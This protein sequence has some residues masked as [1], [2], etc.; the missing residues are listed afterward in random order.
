MQSVMIDPLALLLNLSL[1]LFF[2]LMYIPLIY[3]TVYRVVFEK[4]TKA[5]E[6]MRIMGMTDFPYWSSWLAYYTIVNTAI[7]TGVWF[8]LM[9][10][11]IDR[12]SAFL[13]WV[14]IWVYGQ[15]IFGLILTAQSIF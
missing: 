10:N 3:R 14:I 15:S 13:L 7:A 4:V 8:V 6:S 2:L 9:I 11:V 12:D 5:K 1:T